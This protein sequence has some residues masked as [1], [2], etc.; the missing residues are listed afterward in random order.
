MPNFAQT[1]LVHHGEHPLPPSA[2]AVPAVRWREMAQAA[3]GRRSRAWALCHAC[4]HH[5]P[6]VYEELRDEILRDLKQ[7]CLWTRCCS[8]CTAP[9]SQKRA[10]IAK[11]T[12]WPA[13]ATGRAGRLHRR[14]TGPPLSP[15]RT[16]HR[17]RGRGHHLQG[18]SPHRHRARPKNFFDIIAATAAAR[19]SPTSP[20]TT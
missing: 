15:D 18:I 2:F 7:P 11:A 17:Q 8:T 4:G 14:G 5:D 9:W 3:A 13:S 16:A 10:T 1:Y 6:A 19:S 12:R 20:C